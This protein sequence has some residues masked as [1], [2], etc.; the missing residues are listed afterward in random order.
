MKVVLVNPNYQ[1]KI[2]RI[3]QTTIGPPLGLAYVAASTR[4][5]GHDVTIIDANA[6]ALS[7]ERTSEQALLHGPD[8][9][10][11]TATTPTI[12]LAHHLCSLIKAKAPEVVT[13]VGGPHGTFLPQR[14]LEEFPAFDVVAIGEAELSFP[15]FL[16]AFERGGLE[17]ASEV[18]GFALRT[19]SK[20]ISITGPAA[21]PADL[22]ALPEPA[23]D[24]LPMRL[25]RTTDSDTFTTI[26]AMRG[27]PC[28]CIY[29]AVPA[30][31]GK[32]LRLRSPANVVRE[33]EQVH[34]RYGVD[35]FSF[36][37]DTFTCN[38]KWVVDFCQTLRTSPIG[39]RIRWICLTRPDMVTF[40][41]LRRMREAGCIRVELGIET[42]SDKGRRYLKK[43]LTEAA[44]VEAFT[45]ARRAGLSTMAFIMLNIPF[46]TEEDLRKT[47]ELV[48]RVNPDYLQVSFLT[49]YPGTPLYEEAQRNGWITT[50]E[51]SRY[52]FLNN[53]V[54]DHGSLPHAITLKWQRQMLRDFYLRP[55]TALNLARLILSG[56][57]RMRP[58]LRTALA[59]L[60]DLFSRFTEVKPP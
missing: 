47:K 15:E 48:M 41:L 34:S 13:V 5:Q 24:L 16:R 53:L 19:K 25:Y 38:E 43:G 58:L 6:L 23:R 60:V 27:C 29:C 12:A 21:T 1:R 52:S 28:S 57:A 45:A 46:E 32:R 36:V 10:G 20:G 37:D 33:M 3:A 22:D 31:F 11:V 7:P 40:D 56:K 51:W 44:I 26:L 59:G 18:H 30:H 17:G 54:L 50:Q 2:R 9:I 42:A 4:A 14:V 55:R 35:F 39:P 8:V 49:P